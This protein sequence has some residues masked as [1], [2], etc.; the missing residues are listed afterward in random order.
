MV[1]GKLVGL[2]LVS[3]NVY[4]NLYQN[5]CTVQELGPFSFSFRN[6]TPAKPRRM[7]HLSL[8]NTVARCYQYQCVYEMS[9]KYSKR[10]KIQGPFQCF[11]FWTLTKP[12]PTADDIR[13]SRR[14]DLVNIN[15]HRNILYRS[16]DRA[17]FI[18]FF[19]IWTSVK[20]RQMANDIWQSLG[21]DLVNI[22]VYATLYQNIPY[23]SK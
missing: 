7:I 17:S 13:Q 2:H 18:F 19:R 5:I 15:V 8:G 11:T 10:F 3:I 9:S 22:N 12:R 20:P 16:S 14:L 4:A 1:S 21:L 23:G 6:L